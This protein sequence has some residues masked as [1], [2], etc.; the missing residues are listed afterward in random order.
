MKTITSIFMVSPLQIPRND[1][2]DNE[3]INAYIKDEMNDMQ[4]E[5]CIYLLFHPGFPGKFRKFL[6]REYDRTEAIVNDYDYPN[7]FVVVVYK[8][9]SK[10]ASDYELVKQS[11][12]SKT[13]KDF[14]SQFDY[15][16]VY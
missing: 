14:K 7:G 8:L 10:F 6:N 15:S 12:Y 16:G 5:D 9:D 13:S 3:F 1:L 4:Y 11:K 2:K